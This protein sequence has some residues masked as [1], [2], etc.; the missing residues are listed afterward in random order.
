LRRF[1][2]GEKM[3]KV[4]FIQLREG[5]GNFDSDDEDEMSDEFGT[6]YGDTVLST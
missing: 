4:A 5:E 6:S 2:L 1:F 3:G